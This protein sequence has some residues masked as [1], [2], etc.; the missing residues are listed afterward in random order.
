MNVKRWWNETFC[1]CLWQWDVR[2][3]CHD[4]YY[5]HPVCRQVAACWSWHDT[6]MALWAC[7]LQCHWHCISHAGSEL[8]CKL[9]T[10]AAAPVKC[11][12]NMSAV[13]GHVSL[14]IVPQTTHQISRPQQLTPPASRLLNTTSFHCQ[15]TSLYTVFIAS[16]YFS[17]CSVFFYFC[18]FLYSCVYY[19]LYNCVS[20]CH[21]A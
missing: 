21:L 3:R 8:K 16:Y 9:V 20:G 10:A 4:D 14:W 7:E 11:R 5:Q 6:T 19:C 2:W 1:E 13:D 12:S 15:F 18:L 17:V